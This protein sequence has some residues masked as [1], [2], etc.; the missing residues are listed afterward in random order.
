MA[1]GDRY[2]AKEEMIKL[3]KQYAWE[4]EGEAA[5]FRR[6]NNLIKEAEMKGKSEAYELAAFELEHNME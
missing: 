3:F 1:Y 2:R 6:E 5:K 4:F